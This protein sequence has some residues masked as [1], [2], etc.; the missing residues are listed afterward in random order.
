M[1]MV[2]VA[3]VLAAVVCGCC[4]QREI[5]K[6]PL[7]QY[8]SLTYADAVSILEERRSQIR[9][10]DGLVSAHA[11]TAERSGNFSAKFYLD[12]TGRFRLYGFRQ[13]G[14]TLFDFLL[15]PDEFKLYVPSENRLFTGKRNAE[16]VPQ[17]DA[18]VPL[19]AHRVAEMFC[20]VNFGGDDT[21]QTETSSDENEI[22]IGNS[23]EGRL[24]RR[25]VVDRHTGMILSE[26]VV[27]AD[28]SD[29]ARAAFSDY[30]QVDGAWFPFRIE[31]TR[32]K[33]FTFLIVV[34]ELSVNREPPPTA[35]ELDAPEGAVISN[36]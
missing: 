11:E 9:T 18:K 2:F 27:E 6:T 35:F 29:G 24:I 10:A 36:Q 7:P 30:R 1:T 31:A 16:T 22:V 5:P 13:F 20:W 33:E 8:G 21:T 17:T 3:A 4:L 12:S 23:R 34:T 32:G 14:P 25:T 15:T 26:T 28:G 19:Q